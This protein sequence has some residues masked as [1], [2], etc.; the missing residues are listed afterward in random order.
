[1]RIKLLSRHDVEAGQAQGCDGIISIRGSASRLEPDLAATLTQATR[2]ESARLLR[3]HFDDV[4]LPTYRHLVGPTMAQISAAV[5]FGRAIVSG[6]NLFDGPVENP[7]VAIHC[8]HGQSRSAAVGLALLADHHGAGAERDA[9]NV[10][11]R[12]D[13]NDRQHPN[14]LAISLADSCLWRYGRLEAALAELSPRF[15]RW[16]AVWREIALDPEAAWKK[17]E[18]AVARR[19]RRDPGTA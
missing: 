5:D 15:Y 11:M 4:G 6:H 16:R 3:L 10:L 19:K 8:E 12:D 18:R 14:P 17:A 7:L 1:M 2:G 13:I 9:V